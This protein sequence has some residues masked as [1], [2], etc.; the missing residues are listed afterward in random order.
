MSH[1]DWQSHVLQA[2]STCARFTNRNYGSLP[3]SAITIDDFYNL[4]LTE[5]SFDPLVDSDDDDDGYRGR[6]HNQNGTQESFKKR[7][8]NSGFI[9]QEEV[10][11]SDDV[12][13]FF[14]KL[15]LSESPVS[16]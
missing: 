10:S 2:L 4:P 12:A 1:S 6:D 9:N 16:S 11:T 3:T 7:R 14:Q 5:S 8:L 13:S 15:S